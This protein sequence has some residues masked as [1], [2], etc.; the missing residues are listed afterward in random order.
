VVD[1]IV[2][3]FGNAFYQDPIDAFIASCPVADAELRL[4]W[5]RLVGG[6]DRPIDLLVTC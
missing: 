3:E 2:V 5:Q 6:P 4:G 1:D